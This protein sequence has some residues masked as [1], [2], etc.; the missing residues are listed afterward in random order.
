MKKIAFLLLVLSVFIG[1]NRNDDDATVAPQIGYNYF[2]LNIG[3]T[4]IYKVDSIAYDDNGP[5]QA[6]DTFYYQ[7][8]EHIAETIEDDMGQPLYIINRYYRMHDSDTWQQVRNFAAQIVDNKAKRVEENNRFVRLV[9]P[10]K[11]RNMWDGNLFN[12][13]GNQIYKIVE[14]ETPYVF[15]NNTVKS[16]KVEE[17]NVSNFIE[18]IKRYQTYAE[19]IGRVE[20]MYDSL[21]TQT[22]GTKG[23]RYKLSL[24]SYTP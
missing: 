15:Q 3:S 1:C 13:Q 24:T 9:F 19:N 18:E 7:Y 16:V 14:F 12:A 20:L 8:K 22:S 11:A 17:S 10:L 5:S 21:N 2:P 6:I 4:W 23:F